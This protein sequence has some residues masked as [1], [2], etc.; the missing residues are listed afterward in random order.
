MKQADE[1]LRE[2]KLSGRE[3]FKGRVVHLFED[4]VR[5]PDGSAASREVIRHPGGVGILPLLENGDVLM[6]RQFRYPGDSVLTE[7]PA[8][9]LE[10]GEDALQ[11]GK[12]EL[13]EEI[14]A[15]AAEWRF[16]GNIYPTP[17][18][19]SEVIRIYLA[20]GLTFGEQHLDE[21]EFLNVVRVPLAE[22]VEQVMAGEICDAK[23]QI[24]VLKTAKLLESGALDVR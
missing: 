10:Y 15:E 21:G 13:G 23:T 16:L 14:G 7:I 20:R 1:Q 11:C 22:L 6:V 12:R 3:I 18:Y 24:A 5:L 9:K 19:D 4:Q 8:G 17:A 2:V